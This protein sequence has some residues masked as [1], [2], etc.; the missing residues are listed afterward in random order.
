MAIETKTLTQ[1]Q[2]EFLEQ[3]FY[4]AVTTVRE[5][6]SPHTTVVWVDFDDETVLF[7]TAS[8]RV[9]AAEP[10]AGSA[11]VADRHRPAG[12]LPLDRR[13]RPSWR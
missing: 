1:G 3:N 11:G 13:R 6:G 5:D 12:R 8:G 2:R 10:R 4:A 9:E 7:N